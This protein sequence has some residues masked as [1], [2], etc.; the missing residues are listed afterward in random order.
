MRRRLSAMLLAVIG[1][2]VPVLVALM[3]RRPDDDGEVPS[4]RPTK[5]AGEPSSEHLGAPQGPSQAQ[6]AVGRRSWCAVAR[7][8]AM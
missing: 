6:A 4:S 3:T 8:V 2:G 1:L 7:S 5:P